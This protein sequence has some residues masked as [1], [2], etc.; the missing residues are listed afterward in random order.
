[1]STDRRLLKRL[2]TGQESNFELRLKIDKIDGIDAVRRKSLSQQGCLDHNS[3][4]PSISN[5]NFR[6]VTPYLEMNSS[7]RKK[8]LGD[9]DTIAESEI[10]TP[11]QQKQ[12]K[13]RE[14]MDHPIVQ[15]FMFGIT[16]Y[17]LLGEDLRMGVSPKELDWC[18]TLLNSISLVLFSLEFILGSFGMDEYRFSMFFWLDLVSTVSIITDIEPIMNWLFGSNLSVQEDQ[19]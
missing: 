2:L 8:K 13:V 1:M 6:K 12:K 16:V 19:Q 5:R 3:A 11:M 15:I 4:A 17:I 7:I 14:F 9:K 10:L 18:F